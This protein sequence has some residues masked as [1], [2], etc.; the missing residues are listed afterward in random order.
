M[1]AYYFFFICFTWYISCAVK[2]AKWVQLEREDNKKSQVLREH[3]VYAK[4]Y[5]V[6][7]MSTCML[8]FNWSKVRQIRLSPAIVISWRVCLVFICPGAWAVWYARIGFSWD[9][10]RSHLEY[11]AMWFAF[12]EYVIKVK[13][14]EIRSKC[15]IL[16]VLNKTNYIGVTSI[17]HFSQNMNQKFQSFWVFEV[18]PHAHKST[19]FLHFCFWNIAFET[20]L[21][22]EQTLF[23][24]QYSCFEPT[25]MGKMQWDVWYLVVCA[26]AT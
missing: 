22:T 24:V 15:D 1:Y 3:T 13:P 25:L 18:I 7:R 9:I 2:F 6:I 21:I 26:F 8:L 16:C 14:P 10:C 23:T 20:M 4:W 5:R 19:F 17:K 12:K 11:Y